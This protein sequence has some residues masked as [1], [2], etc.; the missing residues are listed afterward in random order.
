MIQN[1]NDNNPNRLDNVQ[2]KNAKKYIQNTNNIRIE[3][4]IPTEP[5]T[6]TKGFSNSAYVSS[7]ERL[8]ANYFQ[9]ISTAVPFPNVN[10]IEQKEK[11][12]PK[13]KKFIIVLALF[14]I[15]LL[16]LFGCL[17]FII[18]TRRKIENEF[19]KICPICPINQYCVSSSIKSPSCNCKPGYT[20]N[21]NNCEQSFCFKDYE[22]VMD[23]FENATYGIPLIDTEKQK[24]QCC[25]KTFGSCCGVPNND[26]MAKSKRIIGGVTSQMENWPWIVELTQVYRSEP[27]APLAVYVNC[28]G[29]LIT[30]RHVLTAAH[31]LTVD[32]RLEFN[33]E[34]NSTES[35]F[36]VHFGSNNKADFY[37]QKKLSDYERNVTKI[38]IHEEFY[39]DF[40]WNDIAILLLDKPI[41]RSSN[42]DLL[43]LYN[44]GL[45][46]VFNENRKLY[47]AGWGSVNP[48]SWNLSYVDDLHHVDLRIMP[49]NE[50]HYI[51]PSRI[52]LFNATKQVC[53]GYSASS[54]IQKDT[55]YADSGGPLMIKL[56]SQWFSYGIVSY[57]S[58][59][60]C[61]LGPAV[62]TRTAFYYDWIQSKLK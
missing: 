14:I 28:S 29:V 1:Q 24:P 30:E 56:N 47:A 26:I 21:G 39:E 35:F 25:S 18:Y 9:Q 61:A 31:C 49:M 3:N 42:V 55:C 4:I 51:V 19:K 60:D 2:E 48:D 12:K 20:L 45:E 33:E 22:P 34:F 38:I 36:R 62:Y 15:F 10:I 50:C 6:I 52:D 43:C 40:F 11:R 5:F 16:V 8:D 7:I 59:P 57:G 53:A 46:D 58:Q 32:S 37:G 41:E 13:Y 23:F 17:Y 54:K 44:Y 27:D